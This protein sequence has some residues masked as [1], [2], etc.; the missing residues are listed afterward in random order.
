MVVITS[1]RRVSE[2][3]AFIVELLYMVDCKD[4]VQLLS[5]LAF[6]PMVISC[7]LVCIFA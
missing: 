1:A 4:E 5:Y 7:D 2:L 6:L 3:R